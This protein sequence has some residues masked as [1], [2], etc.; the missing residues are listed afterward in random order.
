MSTKRG[1]LG[2]GGGMLATE[3]HPGWVLESQGVGAYKF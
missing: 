2:V 1:L 3:R